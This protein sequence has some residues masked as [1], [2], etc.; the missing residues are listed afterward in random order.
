MVFWGKKTL[1]KRQKILKPSLDGAQPIKAEIEGEKSDISGAHC[2][3][4][5]Q[6]SFANDDVQSSLN[7]AKET[8]NVQFNA[9]LFDLLRNAAKCLLERFSTRKKNQTK[10]QQINIPRRPLSTECFQPSR[11][12]EQ[13]SCGLKFTLGAE[14]AQG[15]GNKTGNTHIFPPGFPK[16][17]RFLQLFS[18]I[19]EL[20]NAFLHLFVFG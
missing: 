15:L 12:S 20:F 7:N 11:T 14:K 4:Q 2:L 1:I 17:V 10:P 6:L 3:S 13:L 5:Q 8:A 19:P 9:S 18:F 16:C